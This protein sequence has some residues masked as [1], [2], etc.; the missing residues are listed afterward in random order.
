[1]R[2]VSWAY[3]VIMARS[4]DSTALYRDAV[5]NDCTKRLFGT[6]DIQRC[7]VTM[8]IMTPRDVAEAGRGMRSSFLTLRFLTLRFLTLRLLN[9]EASL[10]VRYTSRRFGSH[11]GSLRCWNIAPKNVS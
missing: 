7:G 2:V 4:T 8:Y 6:K 9:S 5:G 11:V 10:V 1:M 3:L